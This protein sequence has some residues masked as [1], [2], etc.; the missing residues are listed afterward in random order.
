MNYAL[1][2]RTGT[3]G[4]LS[5]GGALVADASGFRSGFRLSAGI[6]ASI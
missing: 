1:P 6:T 2:K 4:L 3:T 5:V